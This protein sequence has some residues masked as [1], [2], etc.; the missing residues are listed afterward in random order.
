MTSPSTTTSTASC[1]VTANSCQVTTNARCQYKRVNIEKTEYWSATQYNYH[2]LQTAC[3]SAC[4]RAACF[5]VALQ[6]ACTSACARAVSAGRWRRAV[7]SRSSSTAR[8]DSTSTRSTTSSSTVRRRHWRASRSW[9]CASS[10]VVST[11]TVSTATSTA[12][13]RGRPARPRPPPAPRYR[14]SA[15]LDLYCLSVTPTCAHKVFHKLPETIN[16]DTI[17][18]HVCHLQLP[19]QNA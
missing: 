7:T 6:T 13:S 11:P 16:T 19:W 14:T 15:L 5:A 3:T 8:R 10:A 9:C 17:Q 1:Q 4:A 12:A 18:L 2:A